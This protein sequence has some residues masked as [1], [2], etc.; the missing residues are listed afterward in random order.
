M[1]RIGIV[2]HMR[3]RRIVC[4]LVALIMMIAMSTVT[5]DAASFK[6]KP[7]GVKAKCVSGVSVSVSCKAKKGAAGYYFYYSK[8][9]GKNIIILEPSAEMTELIRK[10]LPRGAW[11]E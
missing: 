11:Q 4:L 8:E 2:S 10:Y 7:T 5:A 6:S 1:K 9:Q 3:V